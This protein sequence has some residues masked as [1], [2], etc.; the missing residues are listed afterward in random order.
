MRRIQNAILTLSAAALVASASAALAAGAPKAVAPEPIKEAGFVGKGEKVVHEFVIQNDGDAPLELSDVQAACGCT[1]TSYDRA[2]APG[3]AGK[4]RVELD[5]TTFAGPIAKGVT[6]Y[7][8]DPATPK[9]ELTVRANVQP[10]LAVRPGYARFVKQA[11][12]GKG[13]V[14]QMVW[15]PRGEAFEITKVDSPYP[16][17]EVSYRPATDEDRAAVEATAGGY[18]VDMALDYATAPVGAIADRVVLH[19]TH[20]RQKVVEIPVSGFVR[21]PVAVTPPVVD[22][23]DVKFASQ[24]LKSTLHVQGFADGVDFAVTRFENDLPGIEAAIEPDT[25]AD[26]K[27]FK[28]RLTLK[29]EMPKGVFN[30]TIKLYTNHPRSPVVEVPVKGRVL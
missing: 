22:F 20:P 27:E 4:V 12:Q 24:P 14:E 10:L 25:E 26:G 30:G 28:I 1:A 2:I 29:P 3:A 18:V 9:I 13:K 17:L 5:T 6:V 11:P 16:F 15:S 19:T 23:G 7:T 21:P 8:N